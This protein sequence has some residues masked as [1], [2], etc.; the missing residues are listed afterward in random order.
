MRS[1][2]NYQI[3]HLVIIILL[4]QIRQQSEEKDQLEQVTFFDQFFQ[5]IL[6]YCIIVFE[7]TDFWFSKE[8]TW[9]NKT[10][11]GSYIDVPIGYYTLFE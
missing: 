8:R 5:Y 6:C 3:C 9:N 2:L 7:G 4:F 1:Q 10:V 11:A